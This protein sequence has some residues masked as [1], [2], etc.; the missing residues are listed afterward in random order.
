MAIGIA[1]ADKAYVSLGYG[2]VTL[3]DKHYIHIQ[4]NAIKAGDYLIS[5]SG[6]DEGYLAK[7]LAI[8]LQRF[9]IIRIFSYIDGSPNVEGTVTMVSL[10][11]ADKFTVQLTINNDFNRDT[12][13]YIG[14][15][16]EF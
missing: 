8:C 12:N 16:N 3:E 15:F 4:V 11:E 9:T 2:L 7:I 1:E 10:D 13:L 14:A 6:N 5:L